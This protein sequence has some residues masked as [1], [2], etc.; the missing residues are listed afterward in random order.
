MSNKQIPGRSFRIIYRE[1]D[2]IGEFTYLCPY[3]NEMTLV[4]KVYS[5]DKSVYDILES[6]LFYEPLDCENCGKTT[7]V[8]FLPNMREEY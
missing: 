7:D 8:R 6:G 1:E 4:R 2:A 3:C 5:K